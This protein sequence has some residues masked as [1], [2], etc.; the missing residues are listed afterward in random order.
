MHNARQIQTGVLRLNNMEIIDKVKLYILSLTILFVIVFIMSMKLPQYNFDLCLTSEC[1]IVE[2]GKLLGRNILI[3]YKE[4]WLPVLMYLCFLVSIWIMYD[5]EYMLEGG[6]ENTIRVCNV[7]TEDYEHLTFLAT[8]IIPFFG[9][10]FD[11][12]RRL[13]VYLILLIVIGII[14]IRTDKYFSNPTLALFGFKL[15]KADLSDQ[16]GLYESV[17]IISQDVIEPN[18][19]IKYKLISS[20]VFYAKVTSKR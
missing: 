1:G 11:D 10:N 15:F 5:F 2:W 6:G 8:Y 12:P 14:F 19:V 17:T 3:T 9:F 7:K 18:Q 13:V 16:N 20:N 4:N